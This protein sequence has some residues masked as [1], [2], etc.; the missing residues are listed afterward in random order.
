M[1][2]RYRVIATVLLGLLPLLAAADERHGRPAWH[3]R[4]PSAHAERWSRYEGGRPYPRPGTVF[5]DR[6]RGGYELHYHGDPYFYGGGI[7]Y[8]PWGPRWA[9]IRPPLGVGIRMLPP[10]CVTYWWLGV[11]WYYA[12][13]TYY[14]WAPEREEYI[15]SEPPPAAMESWQARPR[16][17]EQLYAYPKNG[18][19]EAQQSDDRYA[20]HRWAREQAGYDPVQPPEGM[21][22]GEA[23]RRRADYQRAERTCLE[24]KG[25]SVN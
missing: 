21:G 23:A 16:A 17:P 24:G 11:P 20:C 13:D 15:V 7:W 8:R 3:E 22:D 12:Y 18:Q 6:P 9:V 10:R 2:A 5:R 1:N 4:G 19:G 25:Y 14:V